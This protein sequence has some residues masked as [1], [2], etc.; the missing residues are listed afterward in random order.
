MY[1][2]FSGYTLYAYLGDNGS[3]VINVLPIFPG[4]IA[5]EF[6][7]FAVS[8]A[9]AFCEVA[10]GVIFTL[11]TGLG[12]NKN[13]YHNWNGPPQPET[14]VKKYVKDDL[15]ASKAAD[16]LKNLVRCKCHC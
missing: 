4:N 14:Q 1:S 16:L 15:V 8:D 6:V 7:I 3:E 11:P 13:H 10:S 12:R 9:N 2:L 5:S